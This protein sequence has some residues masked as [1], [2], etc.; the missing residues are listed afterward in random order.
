MKQQG[1]DANYSFALTKRSTLIDYKLGGLRK[2]NRKV[3]V[4]AGS[5]IKKEINRRNKR[6]KKRDK[7][8]LDKC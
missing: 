7:N 2:I 4:D 8:L 1:D 6:N 5:E 3:L